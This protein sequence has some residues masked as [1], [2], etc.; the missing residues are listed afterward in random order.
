MRVETFASIA[1]LA[2]APV[3][4]GRAQQGNLPTDIGVYAETTAGT[5]PLK[6][7][8]SGFDVAGTIAG[9]SRMRAL[10][11]PIPTAGDVPVASGIT[12]F[13]VNLPTVQDTNAANAQMHFAVGERVREPDYQTMAVTVGKFRTGV[14]RISSPQMTHEWMANAYAKLT[15]PR[16]Y[17]DK[18]P[19][20]FVGLILNDQMYPVRIDEAALTM[21]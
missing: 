7:T 9:S 17:R 4:A 13:I 20:A 11:F 15:S 8:F 1:L 12:G 18:H 21:K 6:K 14:Y 3:A 10:V 16:K 19:P 2:F 5:I